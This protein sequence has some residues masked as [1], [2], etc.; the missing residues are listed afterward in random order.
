MPLK[1]LTQIFNFLFATIQVKNRVV[2]LFLLG[3]NDLVEIDLTASDPLKLPVDRLVIGKHL[4]D[5]KTQL[6]IIR[7]QC[8]KLTLCLLLQLLALLERVGK[9]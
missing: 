9:L 1:D 2:F 6:V 8:F 5:L 3:F 4:I 7:L